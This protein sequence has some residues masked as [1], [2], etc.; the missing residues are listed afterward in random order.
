MPP[1]K[2]VKL[3]EVVA[4]EWGELG[5][6][7]EPIRSADKKD[8]KRMLH[9]NLDRHTDK[10]CVQWSHGLFKCVFWVALDVNVRI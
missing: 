8:G 7:R 1:A 2:R 3:S 6:P 10:Q 5:G 9:V 4:V